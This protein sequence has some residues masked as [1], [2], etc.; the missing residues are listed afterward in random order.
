[1]KISII[2]PCYN[3]EKYI[4][5]AIESVIFQRGEF[6]IEYVIVDGASNDGTMEIINRY[7][8]KISNREI[9]V[10]C[11]KVEMKII[12]GPD[13][14]MYDALV[15][16]FK[17]V[18]GDII[19]YINSDD[20]YLPN[21]F[22]AVNDIF[23]DNSNILWITGMGIRYNQIGQIINI[24]P[25]CRYDQSLIRKGFYG[26]ILPFIQ[27]ESI[28]WRKELLA[29]LDYEKLNSYKYAG[30]YYIWNTFSKT[31]ALFT[32]KAVLL[33][34]EKEWISCRKINAIIIGNIIILLIKEI[35][36]ITSRHVF[37]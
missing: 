6:E 23:G 2:T 1:M 30:D 28:F 31:T 16:G 19:G 8:H 20:Y 27:Q 34:L 33:D 29:K 24:F 3:S 4:S 10:N 14:G 15:K 9:K 25:L 26:P 12:S 5:E 22:S 13:Q 36:V 17:A 11:N 7:V 18:T 35:F 32:V 37:I 21:A